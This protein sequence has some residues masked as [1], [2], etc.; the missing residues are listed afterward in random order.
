MI[1]RPPRSTLFPYTTLFR[2]LQDAALD[3][4]RAASVAELGGD[5]G[6]ADA[7]RLLDGAG[8]AH[9]VGEAIVEDSPVAVQVDR[10]P[11][12]VD[13]GGIARAAAFNADTAHPP[14]PSA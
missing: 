2:S 5:G 14:V 9:G 10:R 12:H 4:D 13:H 6:G 11:R 3:S 8:V 7:G 1:R